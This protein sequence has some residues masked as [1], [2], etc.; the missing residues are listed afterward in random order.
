MIRKI[1]LALVLSA[2]V[3]TAAASTAE[4]SNG[5]SGYIIASS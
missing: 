5:R 3:M 1:A 2:C 4:N